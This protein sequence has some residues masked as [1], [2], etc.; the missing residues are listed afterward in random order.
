MPPSE[1]LTTKGHAPGVLVGNDAKPEFHATA[2]PAGSAP[3]EATFKPQ[4]VGEVPTSEGAGSTA[5]ADTLGGATSADVHQGYGLPLKGQT[6]TEV[7]KDGKH[8]STK[9]PSGLASVGANA[10]PDPVRQKGAD[11][12]EGVVKGGKSKAD[13]PSAT[14]RLPEG[15]ETVANE[16]SGPHGRAYA[17]GDKA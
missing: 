9:E 11:L 8:T 15:A 4:P 12:P 16:H 5:A 10:G 6:A 17:H 14:E 1:P 7:R 3:A 2:V 13:A